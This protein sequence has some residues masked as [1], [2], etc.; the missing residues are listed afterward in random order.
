MKDERLFDC[1]G[2]SGCTRGNVCDLDGGCYYAKH[3]IPELSATKEPESWAATL[4]GPDGHSESICTKYP[5]VL[6]KWLIAHSE[7]LGTMVA[8]ATIP[9]VSD[10]VAMSTAK[11]AD[12]VGEG[13][14]PTAGI[15]LIE[16]RCRKA[17]PKPG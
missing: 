11:I 14:C 8:M 9:D 13:D 6:L 15:C 5:D 4:T 1:V 7:R 3:T 16:Q 12:C 10:G 17:A 2:I